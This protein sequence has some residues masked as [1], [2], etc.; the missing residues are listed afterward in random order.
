MSKNMRHPDGAFNMDSD[1]DS[2]LS[3]TLEDIALEAPRYEKSED[4]VPTIPDIPDPDMIELERLLGEFPEQTEN[5]RGAEIA[6]LEEIPIPMP[7]VPVLKDKSFKKEDTVVLPPLI[8]PIHPIPISGLPRPDGESDYL[9]PGNKSLPD[10]E[11][12]GMDTDNDR[13]EKA[14]K[15]NPVTVFFFFVFHAFF[16]LF[17]LLA[18]LITVLSLMRANRAG[19]YEITGAGSGSYAVGD[20]VFVEEC[21]PELIKIEDNILIWHE[22]GALL[23]VRILETK[24]FNG[25]Q[26][27]FIVEG[28]PNSAEGMFVVSNMDRVIGKITLGLPKL[29]SVLSFIERYMIVCLLFAA[30]VIFLF[31]LANWK[32]FKKP[33]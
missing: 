2:L 6:K 17:I 26:L 4:A 3:K 9:I 22:D 18:V 29:G 14:V 12:I 21:A 10:Y 13:E 31:V 7:G 11:P 16:Y 27:T 28:N 23:P 8:K 19:L 20:L 5:K 30:A 33:R 32:Y 24:E 15:R 25:E 1:L